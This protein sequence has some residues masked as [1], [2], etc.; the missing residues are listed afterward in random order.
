MRSALK[1]SFIS[2]RAKRPRRFTQAPRLVETVTSGE[3]VTMR[4]AKGSPERASSLRI[5]PKPCCVDIAACFGAAMASG[6]GICGASSRRV[7]LARNGTASRNRCSLSAGIDSPS[8]LSHSW[9]G[10]TFTLAR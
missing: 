5:S 4:A 6:T 3:V 10:R 8:N 2:S 9:P 1:V 7:P